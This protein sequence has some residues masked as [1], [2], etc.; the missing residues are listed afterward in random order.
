MIIWKY[1]DQS[2]RV[3]NSDDGR[4]SCLASVLP[5]GTEIAEP[6]GP[7]QAER[8]PDAWSKDKSRITAWAASLIGAGILSWGVWST[9]AV[10]SLQAACVLATEQIKQADIQTRERDKQ[11]SELA[12]N[13]NASL[14]AQLARIE[15]QLAEIQRE[16]RRGAR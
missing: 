16:L 14:Q 7:T 1:T 13:N 8:K 11:L 5:E 12:A 10:F 2:R 4:Q 9:V 15:A 6:D 3:A